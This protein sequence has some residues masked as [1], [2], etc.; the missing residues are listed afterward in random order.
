[1]Y[2]VRAYGTP[3]SPGMQGAAPGMAHFIHYVDEITPCSGFFL[4]KRLQRMELQV[5]RIDGHLDLAH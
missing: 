2:S 5:E 3:K 1:M 4:L